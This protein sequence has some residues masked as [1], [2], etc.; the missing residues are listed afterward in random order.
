MYTLLWRVNSCKASDGS[1]KE[2]AHQDPHILTVIT[3][4]VDY[5][6]M[7]SYE[8]TESELFIN[9]IGETVKLWTY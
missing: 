5:S 2:I 8:L 6:G 4:T 7:Y 1:D 9:E 3:P